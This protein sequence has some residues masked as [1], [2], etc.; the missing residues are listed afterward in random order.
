[1]PAGRWGAGTTPDR[2]SGRLHRSGGAVAHRPAMVRPA[3]EVAD[4]LRDHGPA[5]PRDFVPWRFLDAGPQSVGA[6]RYCP[7][8]KT[9][10]EP[11]VTFHSRVVMG[12]SRKSPW[13][14]D[15][16]GSHAIQ[17]YSP[18]FKRGQTDSSLVGESLSALL[19]PSRSEAG[20]CC[21]WPPQHQRFTPGQAYKTT[22]SPTLSRPRAP[23]R[24][25]AASGVHAR[26]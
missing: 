13:L 19:R 2:S 10:T 16:S 6:S 22:R 17:T 12:D 25:E 9:C 20:I 11:E 23:A 8:P 1:M 5:W 4:I 21:L 26:Q 18:A 7:R 3:L 24:A 14:S 15:P